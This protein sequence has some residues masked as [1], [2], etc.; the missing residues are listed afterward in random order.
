[1]KKLF[2]A[3]RYWSSY[4]NDLVRKSFFKQQSYWMTSYQ[5][6]CVAFF[7]RLYVACKFENA[8][9]KKNYPMRMNIY[10]HHCQI[11]KEIWW[12]QNHSKQRG[13]KSNYWCSCVG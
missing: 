3:S 1:M 13:D 5:R 6:T 8:I 4:S 7:S 2:E 9:F 10:C 12:R 11:W